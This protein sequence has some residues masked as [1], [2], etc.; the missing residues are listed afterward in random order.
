VFFVQA[1]FGDDEGQ[2]INIDFRIIKKN[3][4]LLI[5]DIIPEG[6]SFIVTQRSEVNSSISNKGFE[7][8]LEHL[9]E[10]QEEK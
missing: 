9:R 7:N 5:S 4:N 8:F 2:I 6:I 10:L 1:E 3:G